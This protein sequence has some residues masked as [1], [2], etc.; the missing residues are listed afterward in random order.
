MG[1][2]TTQA[3]DH[4]PA[5]VNALDAIPDDLLDLPTPPAYLA[6]GTTPCA[7]EAPPEIDD[8]ETYVIRVRCTGK[9]SSERTDGELRHGRKL[10]IQWCIKQGQPEP[11][12]AEQ[13][14][15]GL[16]DDNDGYE[17]S[18]MDEFADDGPEVDRPGFSDGEQ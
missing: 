18:G 9:S 5:N 2:D 17:P 3:H 1:L 11:P 14:Q 6:F 13:E 15:P 12:D 16:F 7:L 4:P 8:V 10:Q